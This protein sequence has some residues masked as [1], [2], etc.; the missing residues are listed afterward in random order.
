MAF[1]DRSPNPID[2]YVGGRVR[3]RRKYL[4]LSQTDIAAA[5]NL[6]FQQIQ[7]YERGTNRISASKMYEM[8]RTLKVPVAYFFEGFGA[9]ARD[10]GF[11]DSMAESNVKALL[12]TDEGLE[13]AAAFPRIASPDQRRKILDL[14][15]TLADDV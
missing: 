2:L 13:M 6:T 7:K 11:E 8:A 12:L 4:N 10:E 9:G 1:D 5:L 14:I 3:L 15:Q